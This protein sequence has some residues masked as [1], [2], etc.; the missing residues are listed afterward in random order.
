MSMRGSAFLFVPINR[1]YQK[2]GSLKPIPDA[3]RVMIAI[4]IG[5]PDMENV[6]NKISSTHEP[7]GGD[8]SWIGFPSPQRRWKLPQLICP[9]WHNGGSSVYPAVI[10]I[11]KHSG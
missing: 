2:N 9:Q 8:P 10:R 1:Q 6:V 5:Y 3:K 4:S 7:L 11:A